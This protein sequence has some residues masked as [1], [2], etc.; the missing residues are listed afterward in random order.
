MSST[1]TS[2]TRAIS[3]IVVMTFAGSLSRPRIVCGARNGLSV[4]TRMRSSVERLRRLTEV[5]VLRIRDVAR[6]A[7]PVAARRALARDDRVAAEAVDHDALRRSLIQYSKDVGPRVADVDHERLAGVVRQRDL[8]LERA[9]LV[10]PGRMHPEVVQAALP[11]GQHAGVVQELLDPGA[12]VPVERARRRGGACLPWRTHPRSNRPA[13]ATG[14]SF[15]GPR[16]RRSAD[17]RR[18]PSRPRPHLKV[19]CR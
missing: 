12:G 14:G 2:R 13:R 19:R 17:R 9:L 10:L 16:R 1:S 4:S 6:E 11:H 7:H 18:R 15:R 3:A 5:L 8:R